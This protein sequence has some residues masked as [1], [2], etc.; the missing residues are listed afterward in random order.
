M[1]KRDLIID[2][3]EK[4]N[5]FLKQIVIELFNLNQANNSVDI[6]TIFEKFSSHFKKSIAEISNYSDEEL[7]KFCLKNNF[8]PSDY[9]LLAEIFVQICQYNFDV[10]YLQKAL[11]L[12]EEENNLSDTYSIERNEKINKIINL[13]NRT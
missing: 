5:T 2:E 13:I 7:Q 4:L 3:I 6:N 1:E 9:A 12:L 8:K 10:K 11:F